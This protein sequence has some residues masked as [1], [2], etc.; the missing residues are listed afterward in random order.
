MEPHPYKQCWVFNP[1]SHNRNP[2]LWVIIFFKSSFLTQVGNLFVKYVE[3]I[4]IFLFF[5]FQHPLQHMELPG[6]GSD[7]SHSCNLCC[8]LRQCQ[9]LNPLCRARMEPTSPRSQDATVANRNSKREDTFFFSFVFL[10]LHPQHM[11]VPRLGASLHHS[12]S[13]ARFEL[14]LLPTIQLMATAMLNP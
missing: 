12:H 13:N 11:E 5:L 7:L 2:L 3:R 9:I 8:S 1:L 6:Q 10:G 14:H 4:H